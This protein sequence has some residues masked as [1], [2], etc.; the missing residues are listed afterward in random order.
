MPDSTSLQ[1]TCPRCAIGFIPSRSNQKFCS[2]ICQKAAS[3]HATRLPRTIADSPEER[4]R[5]RGRS[6]RLKG[7]SEAFYGTLPTY[8]APFMVALIAEA[9]GKAELRKWLSKRDL[10][11]SW[12]HIAHCLNHF[13]KEVYGLRSS[14][15]LDPAR[16]LPCVVKTAFPAEYYG[17]DRPPVY[18]DGSLKQRP[19]AWSTRPLM[20]PFRPSRVPPHAYDWLKIGRGMDDHGWQRHIEQEE[21]DDD[22]PAYD[23]LPQQD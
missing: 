21:W 13:C 18:E 23:F 22:K 20:G 17:P 8:R 7:L 3:L 10:L 19:S 9:R 1:P 5:Q 11:R 6:G 4:R 12:G 16:P 14:I 15:I 2:R